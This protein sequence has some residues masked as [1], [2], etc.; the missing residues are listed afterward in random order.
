MIIIDSDSLGSPTLSSSRA[1][2]TSS[3]EHSGSA[4][5][6]MDSPRNIQD[7]PEGNVP[8]NRRAEAEVPFDRPVSRERQ[9]LVPYNAD[10]IPTES[11][12]RRVRIRYFKANVKDQENCILV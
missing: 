10:P 2:S 8:V 11:G 9:S 6:L 7:S 3:S 5:Q 1:P 12:S 4:T